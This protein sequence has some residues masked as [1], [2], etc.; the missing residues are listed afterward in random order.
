MTNSRTTRKALVSSALAVLMC[1]AMLIGTTFAWFTDTASTS[2]NKIQAGTLDIALEMNEG[3]TAEPNWVTAEGKTLAFKKAAGAPADEK[4][5]WEPGCTY[6]LPEIRLVNEGN[7]ALKYK[8]QITGIQGDAKLN[9]AIEW[10]IDGLDLDTEGHLKAEETSK[11]LTIKGH[12][13]EEA[14]NEYQGLSI[15][16]ISITV[17]ATQDTVEYDSA[18][19]QYDADAPV[20][21]AA[22][23]AEAQAI[24][25]SADGYA[26]IELAAGNYETL[27]LRQTLDSS[28]RRTDL[29][30]NTSYP[31]YY[32]E[33]NN[34]TIKAADGATVICDG[35]KVEAGLFWYSNAPASNQEAMNRAASGF[36]SFLSLKNISI[37]GITFNNTDASAV[38]LRDNIAADDKS[39]LYVN[40][41]TVKNCKGTGTIANKDQH[42]FSAGSGSNDQPFC[43]VENGVKGLNNLAI[44]GCEITS[45][46]QPIHFNNATA[47]LNGLTVSGNTFTSCDNNHVQISNKENR[48]VFTFS[49]NTLVK[50]NGR[51]VRMAAAQSDTVITVDNTTVTSPVKYDDGTAPEIFKV[52][53]VEGFKV[54]SSDNSGWTIATDDGTT[55]TAHGNTALLSAG[56]Y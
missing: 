22:T 7:L 26:V 56:T 23:T 40:G 32:R 43:G 47:I 27:Y 52:T 3:T 2:V 21:K 10:T 14:G 39:T 37:D 53:G 33:F 17:V 50:M 20:Y 55:W 28:T 1:M 54:S 18:D 8:I 19:N 44:I 5:L 25:D 36:L 46:Y 6:E 48:G 15:D 51:F 45:Y 11:V 4:V 42:F 30:K 9:D 16:G 38:V 24:L 31:A 35:I 41:F 34:V 13:K 29:D 12:M 49:D